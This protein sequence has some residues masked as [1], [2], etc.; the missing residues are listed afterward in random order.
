MHFCTA[1]IALAGDISQLVARGEFNPVS[2]PEIDVLRHIHGEAAITQVKPFVSV[3]QTA[4]DEKARLQLI[5]GMDVLEEVFPGRNPQMELEAADAKLPATTPNW[6]SPIDREPEG[7]DVAPESKQTK[8]EAPS[9][10]APR[11]LTKDPTPF[12]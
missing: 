6:R 10:A 9:K 8:A 2:W 11:V 12:A 3:Q 4:K 5:Y 7:Y 1:M